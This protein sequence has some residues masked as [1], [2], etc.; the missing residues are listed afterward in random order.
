MVN[1]SD[2]FSAKDLLD[3]MS[4]GFIAR[5]QHPWLS[6]FI[7]NYTNRAQVTSSSWDNPAV[8]ICRGL[9][10][11]QRG[12]VLARPFPKFWNHGEP[13]AGELRLDAPVDVYDKLDG[14]LGILYPDGDGYSVATRG[15]FTSDQALHATSVWKYR[16]EGVFKPTTGFTFLVEIVYPENRIVLDYS[17]LDDLVLLAVVENQTGHI[18]GP[19]FAHG[20]WPGPVAEKTEHYQLAHALAAVPRE[21][22]EGLVIHLVDE[23]QLVKIK[24][25][26][27]VRLHKAVFGLNEQTVWEHL[28]LGLDIDELLETLPDELHAWT[29]STAEAL[30]ERWRNRIFDAMAKHVDVLL[31]IPSDHNRKDYALKAKELCGDDT[32]LLP[33]LFS[34]LDGKP[35]HEAVWKQLKP[36]YSKPDFRSE[37]EAA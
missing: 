1:I 13:R 6:L 25:E 23:N 26:D 16:Y 4:H 10:V 12:D 14:S 21:N 2:L 7:Y 35:I 30:T 37:E 18:S 20:D 9:I 33:L 36:A 11:D 17:G 29:R 3:G 27:Y 34:L 8:G 32:A 19:W 5:K 22:A 15:S 31:H 28:S 24:Q